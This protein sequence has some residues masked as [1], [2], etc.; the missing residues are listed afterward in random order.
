MTDDPIDITTFYLIFLFPIKLFLTR[1]IIC[2]LDPPDGR[3][4]QSKLLIQRNL[5]ASSWAAAGALRLMA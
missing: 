4:L 2:R 1:A 3:I 5:L